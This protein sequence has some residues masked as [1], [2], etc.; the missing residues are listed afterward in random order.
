MC[1]SGK[2]RLLAFCEQEG[3]PH[4]M[5]GKV[6]VATTEP[7]VARIRM[8]RDR[9]RQNGVRCAL[10]GPEALQ[11]REPHAQGLAA[12]LVQD[13][14]IV[15]Y[16]AAL[17]RKAARAEEQGVTV[18]TKAPVQKIRATTSQVTLVTPDCATEARQ[19]LNCAGLFAD[20]MAM[21]GGQRPSVRIVPFRGEYYSLRADVKDRCRHL[22]Y[23]AGNAALPLLGI[24]LTRMTDGHVFCG[25]SAVLGFAREGYHLSTVNPE[26]LAGTLAYGGFLRLAARHW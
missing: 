5:C 6:I 11:E 19:V 7:E 13:A 9:G 2:R 1:L 14:G 4:E 15:D 16:R 17:L 10:L 8:L 18:V 22:I 24:H 25:P 23:P 3:V 12:L 26:N 20:Q 21:L